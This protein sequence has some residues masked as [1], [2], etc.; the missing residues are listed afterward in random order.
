[1]RPEP[2][3]ADASELLVNAWQ[4]MPAGGSVYL[5]TKRMDLHAADIRPYDVKQ[6]YYVRITVQDTGSGMDERTRQRIFEPFFTTKQMGRGTGLGLATVYG[7]SK[8]R[9]YIPSTANRAMEPGSTSTCLCGS[10]T[11]PR[12]GGGKDDVVSGSGVILLV[13]DGSGSRDN[14]GDVNPRV[15]RH[16]RAERQEAIALFRQEAPGRRSDPHGH[17]HA[18]ISGSEAVDAL[19]EIDPSV[20]IV[21]ASG[22][23]L[24]GLAGDI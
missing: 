5:E 2:D 6:G 24:N 15:H 16:D 12:T 7:S 23:S 10:R 13:E 19:M 4:A 8:A 21:L 18:G 17:E 3:G 9:G 22:Y 20:W 1:M 11:A 14:K